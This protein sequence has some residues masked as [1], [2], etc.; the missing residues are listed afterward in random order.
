MSNEYVNAII[1]K[2]LIDR[3]ID[4][5]PEERKNWDVLDIYFF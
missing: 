3:L 1:D 5:S 2:M 4:G